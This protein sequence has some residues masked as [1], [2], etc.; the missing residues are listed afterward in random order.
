MSPM[1]ERAAAPAAPSVA[2]RGARGGGLGRWTLFLTLLGALLTLAEAWFLAAP[3][4]FALTLG[5]G[6]A[7]WN[8]IVAPLLALVAIMGALLL[9]RRPLGGMTCLLGA[10]LVLLFSGGYALAPAAVL[11]CVWAQRR[12]AGA[13]AALGFILLLPGIVAGYY[14]VAAMICFT[15]GEAMPGMPPSLNPPLSLARALTPFAFLPLALLGAWMLTG[16]S[17]S[18]S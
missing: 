7:T 10:A 18:R 4:P 13:R 9:E 8:Q 3:A 11:G 15:S 17:P 6:A 12:H 16:K 1:P 5:I 14:G 2:G